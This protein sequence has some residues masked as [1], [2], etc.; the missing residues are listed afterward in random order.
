M[1]SFGGIGDTVV[2]A[3]AVEGV[4]D[5]VA[6]AIYRAFDEVADTVVIVVQVFV[7]EYQIAVGVTGGVIDTD[8]IGD[9]VANGSGEGPA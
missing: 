8:R 7:V 5:A 3:V 6:I 1:V 9:R 4:D 2:I